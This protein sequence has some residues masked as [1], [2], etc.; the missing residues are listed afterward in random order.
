M[1]NHDQIAHAFNNRVDSTHRGEM[2]ASHRG[3]HNVMD[4]AQ[5]REPA[6]EPKAANA[7]SVARGGEECYIVQTLLE[8]ALQHLKT[9]VA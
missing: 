1:Q 4:G 6:H 5:N 2:I 3:T 8:C 9:R 7:V